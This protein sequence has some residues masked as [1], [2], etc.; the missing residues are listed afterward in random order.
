M[1]YVD[2]VLFDLGN[3]LVSYYKPAEFHPVL[4]RCVAAVT[5]L[6]QSEGHQVVAASA[7]ERAKCLNKERPDFRVWPLRERLKEIFA[8]TG[9]PLTDALMEAM[10]EQFLGPILATGTMN[11][12]AIPVLR[13]LKALGLKCA[14]LSNTPWGSPAAA[15]RNELRRW[16][17]LEWVDTAV[18]CVDVG[19][20]KPA[21]QIF[22]QALMCLG[23]TA[24]RALFVGDDLQW[25]VEGARSA[26]IAPVL[27]SDVPL[28]VDDCCVIQRLAELIPMLQSSNAGRFSIGR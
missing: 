15:W 11:P 28:S 7:F 13:Q 19:W 10:S 3:T 16:G 1:R 21:P 2:A 27:L 23:V 22:E 20:R 4:E 17:L 6:L 9:E 24:A 26:G 25:D 8:G 18:F 14:I 5:R 12:E